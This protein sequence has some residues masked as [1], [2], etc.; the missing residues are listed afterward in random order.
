MLS[1][2]EWMYERRKLFDLMRA[3]P[4]WSFRAY[5]REVQHDLQWVRKWAKRWV[6]QAT[7]TD[8]ALRSRSR[9]PQHSPK[10]LLDSVKDTIGELRE[11]LS[12]R[13]NRA[14]GPQLIA[15]FLGKT[16]DADAKSPSLSSIYKTLVERGYLQARPK[17]DHT[18]LVL[19]APNEEW[20]LDF[21]EI[22]L[23]LEEGRLEFMVVVD[24]G[25]S[26]VVY[27]EGSSGYRAESAIDAVLRL[28]AA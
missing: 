24:K 8:E 15:Y 13:F 14:A 3:Y 10:Q 21:G 4:E 23:G 1:E 22:Y 27:L 28:F 9:R 17:V 20:E 11:T 16:T 2:S 25:T 26:R 19:P 7:M 6:G 12:E 5:A 18:P